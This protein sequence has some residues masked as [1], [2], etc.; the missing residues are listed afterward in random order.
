MEETKIFI[1]GQ[2]QTLKREVLKYEE[3]VADNQ[4]KNEA[5]AQLKAR[6]EAEQQQ[7]C[8][9]DTQFKTLQQAEGDLKGRYFQLECELGE[10]KNAV[11]EKDLDPMLTEQELSDL[12]QQLKQVTEDLNSANEKIQQVE[13]LRQEQEK[14]SGQLEVWNIC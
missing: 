4:K 5:N 6:L 1:K 8:H 10:I 7:Y 2:M 9:L 13:R 12:R 11:R 3:V 14:K